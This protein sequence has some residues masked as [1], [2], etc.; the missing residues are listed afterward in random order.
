MKNFNEEFLSHASLEG[1]AM[2]KDINLIGNDFNIENYINKYNENLN[3]IQYTIEK[4]IL[5]ENANIRKNAKNNNNSINLPNL[6]KSANRLSIIEKKRHTNFKNLSEQECKMVNT[7]NIFHSP[8]NRQNIENTNN[9]NSSSKKFAENFNLKKNFIKN[10]L[11][12]SNFLAYSEKANKIS[13][14][15]FILNKIKN[16]LT[17]E[18]KD[19][20]SLDKLDS[21]FRLVLNFNPQE[22]NKA[23]KQSTLH[24]SRKIRNQDAD[25][26]NYYKDI[27]RNN[28]NGNV[29]KV[30]FDESHVKNK[31]IKFSIGKSSE[32]H[33][34]PQ[35]KVAKKDFEK[36]FRNRN[37]SEFG[38]NINSNISRNKSNFIKSNSEFNFTSEYPNGKKIQFN[39]NIIYNDSNISTQPHSILNS[40][41]TDFLK[42]KESLVDNKAKFISSKLS[43]IKSFSPSIP[44]NTDEQGLNNL[45]RSSLLRNKQ[46]EKNI[47]ESLN[48][49]KKDKHF[50]NLNSSRTYSDLDISK[51]LKNDNI[52]SEDKPKIYKPANANTNA[53]NLDQKRK[54][55]KKG[56]LLVSKDNDKR[57]SVFS[58]NKTLKLPPPSQVNNINSYSDQASSESNV[59]SNSTTNF[60]NNFNKSLKFSPNNLPKILEECIGLEKE[61]QQINDEINKISDN[62]DNVIDSSVPN[63][64][65]KFKEEIN[66]NLNLNDVFLYGNNGEGYYM[67]NLNVFKEADILKRL[68]SEHLLR[69]KKFFFQRFDLNNK[70]D[71]KSPETFSEN[72]ILRSQTLVNFKKIA[73]FLKETEELKK[74]NINEINNFQAKNHI[75]E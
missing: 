59:L 1:M 9:N 62:I 58:L 52:A 68:Q 39:K 36:L 15:S 14:N 33:I 24:D 18:S 28:N 25:R 64:Q 65:K 4:V 47:I 30:N 66:F 44:P 32:L 38:T 51:N 5:G 61:T 17:H 71:A 22:N 34:N 40:F 63:K 70:G 49:A 42:T 27:S 75:H 43:I 26:T 7:N 37:G 74:K 8:P 46:I 73:D 19:I 3:S 53:F 23:T 56:S 10:N 72:D 55:Q 16:N 12:H 41:N 13:M 20:K 54:S 57:T 48:L 50:F 6:K 21:K 11:Q 29:R 35:P 45:Q 67:S 2:F 60:K 31:S 69:H